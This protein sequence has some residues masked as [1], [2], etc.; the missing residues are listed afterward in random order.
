[1]S[2]GDSTQ[3][4]EIAMAM[5]VTQLL[6]IIAEQTRKI[7]FLSECLGI[8]PDLDVEEVPACFTIYEGHKGF[9]PNKKPEKIDITKAKTDEQVEETLTKMLQ[10]S[11]VPIVK[12]VLN[13]DSKSIVR[14]LRDE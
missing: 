14:I 8:E 7:E 4:F 10:P 13:P 6:Q 2:N 11:K 12:W 3:K 5:Q 1:M 9:D